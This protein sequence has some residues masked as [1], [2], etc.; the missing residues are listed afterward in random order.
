M[1]QSF[2]SLEEAYKFY[3]PRTE[4]FLEWMFNSAPK[5]GKSVPQAATLSPQKK[6][7][8]IPADDL[9]MFATAIV[10][11]EPQIEIPREILVIAQEAI[12]GRRWSRD[13][14]SST[15]TKTERITKSNS[16]HQYY[17]VELE[18]AVA[19]L[20]EV[21]K[22]RQPELE[23]E[24]DSTIRP[25]SMHNIFLQLNIEDIEDDDTPSA[26]SLKDQTAQMA[27]A[28]SRP[29]PEIS[30]ELEDDQDCP[31]SVAIS[32][33]LNDLK[34]IRE[35][36][37]AILEK[38]LSGA[39]T[40]L[41][42]CQTIEHAVQLSLMITDDFHA[43][44]PH[45]GSF[46]ELVDSFGSHE[47]LQVARS[48]ELP[49]LA[50][51]CKLPFNAILCLPAWTAV[52]TLAE[53]ASLL[54]NQE[55]T[56][57]FL[58]E[59]MAPGDPSH[60]F[61][62]VLIG[63]ASELAVIVGVSRD[64]DNANQGLSLL[65]LGDGYTKLL[66]EFLSSSSFTTGFVTATQLQMD[67]FDCLAGTKSSHL[68]ECE[69]SLDAVIA[70]TSDYAAWYARLGEWERQHLPEAFHQLEILKTLAIP[71]CVDKT[72]RAG[73]KIQSA[74]AVDG[75][76]A[77]PCSV[78]A[79]L[80]QAL[81][82]LAGHIAWKIRLIV[83][84]NG[85]EFCNDQ[86][87]ILA[88]THLHHATKL[89]SAPANDWP[90][91]DFAVAQ[92]SS[93]FFRQGNGSMLSAAR[94]FSVALGLPLT[95]ATSATR[96]K[97]PDYTLIKR[98]DETLEAASYFNDDA[99]SNLVLGGTTSQICKV[100]DAIRAFA[101]KPGV[102]DVDIAGQW[103]ETKRLSPCQVLVVLGEIV[104]KEEKGIM[105]N[106]LDLLRRCFEVVDGL[107]ELCYKKQPSIS[108][109]LKSSV[110][111]TCL[112]QQVY[113]ILWEAADIEARGLFGFQ[114]P[115]TVARERIKAVL[116]KTGGASR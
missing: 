42:A 74:D 101:A 100:Y 22:A 102:E 115:L 47:Y 83:H 2:G 65:S 92:Q 44:Y 80:L 97:C 51:S 24:T 7:V 75:Q 68:K 67:F 93:S 15:P 57:L 71:H 1:S 3:K 43:R 35:Q 79:Y 52:C 84:R 29:A 4:K 58:E 91:L 90:E 30:Y 98:K 50:T 16:S 9:A 73:W 103:T 19:I 94:M 55:D 11:A 60:P 45:L 113:D 39:I 23:E 36:V 61:T 77:E 116:G 41:A 109:S 31:T 63:V 78:T 25:K 106:Y 76:R 20:A 10:D 104:L 34:D 33:L 99:T 86:L 37:T 6:L 27:T 95:K 66:C 96:P 54:R 26:E 112:Y 114:S 32:S 12:F 89:L 85:I 17:L 87:I 69:A 70:E 108:P 14:Y 81:P 48:A 13:R 40:F 18:R 53:L 82:M 46:A 38:Y 111:G 59:K 56:R 5:A 72:S 64:G 21:S 62:K 107:V 28:P 88:A 49:S 105:F 110:E 8:K